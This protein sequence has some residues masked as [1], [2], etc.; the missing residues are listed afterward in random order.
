MH[1][2]QL[3]RM[4]CRGPAQ[5]APHEVCAGRQRRLA[6]M[7][8]VAQAAASDDH[9]GQAAGHFI[10]DGK[11]HLRLQHGLGPGHDQA[12]AGILHRVPDHLVRPGAVH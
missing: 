1:V 9:I 7:P 11:H 3:R 2:A 12:E 10:A 6:R 8:D 5:L 4:C